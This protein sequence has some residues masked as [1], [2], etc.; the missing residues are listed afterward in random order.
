MIVPGI[1]GKQLAENF[2]R[3]ELMGNDSST[4]L[5]LLAERQKR[6]WEEAQQAERLERERYETLWLDYLKSRRLE[7]F[8]AACEK[9][10]TECKCVVIAG[11]S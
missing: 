2:T 9:K 8:C 7:G 11:A 1:S 6:K 3:N 4:K 10:L 5:K